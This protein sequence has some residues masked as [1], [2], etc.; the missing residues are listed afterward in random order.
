MYI[1]NRNI[2]VQFISTLKHWYLYLLCR[3]MLIISAYLSSVLPYVWTIC[4][5]P[6]LWLTNVLYALFLIF[7]VIPFQTQTYGNTELRYVDIIS[8]TRHSK[9][10]YQCFIVEINCTCI[11]LIK[12][13]ID[14]QAER[15][16]VSHKLGLLHIVI[17]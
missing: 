17:R 15:T 1:F 13:Y 9:C 12:I 5:K 7:I 6:S 14:T 3:V 11:F 10:W 16:F 4:N 2:P 8:I